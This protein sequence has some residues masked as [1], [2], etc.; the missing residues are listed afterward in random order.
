MEVRELPETGEVEVGTTRLAAD[1]YG[2]EGGY[3]GEGPSHD[4]PRNLRFAA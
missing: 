1:A 2:L 3:E 4:G